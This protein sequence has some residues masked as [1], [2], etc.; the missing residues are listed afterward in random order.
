MHQNLE[1][2]SEAVSSNSDK[3]IAELCTKLRKQHKKVACQQIEIIRW[4]LEKMSLDLPLVP[5]DAY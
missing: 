5:F 1:L 3:H 4:W 2:C